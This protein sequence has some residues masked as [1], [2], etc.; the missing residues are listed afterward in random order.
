M[1]SGSGKGRV[2]LSAD[3]G[4]PICY[5]GPMRR[6]EAIQRLRQHRAEF[7]RLGVAHMRLFGSI[8]RDQADEDSDVDVIVE[9]PEGAPMSLFKL[10]SIS[11]ELER[12]LGRSVDVFPQAGLDHAKKFHARVAP[13]LIDVF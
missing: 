8:A 9:P 13:E 7:A 2:T 11:D 10:M 4:A 6:D 12:I 1:S 5:A 3:G